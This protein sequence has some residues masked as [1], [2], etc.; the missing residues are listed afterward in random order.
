[1]NWQTR[2]RAR[3]EAAGRPVSDAVVEELA[4][5]AADVE[6]EALAAGETAGS[7]AARV[8]AEV[9]AWV[10]ELPSRTRRAGG[11]PG[12]LHQPAGLA[13]SLGRDLSHALRVLVRQKGPSGVG[14]V[15]I[16]LAIG[17][18]R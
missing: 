17:P 4:E 11:A 3:F 16:A 9:A 15:T 1:M 10:R 12:R 18:W 13:A 7:A 2:L 6:R 5:H 8:E 14:V